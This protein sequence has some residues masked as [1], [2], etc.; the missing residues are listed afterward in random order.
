MGKKIVR[1]FRGKTD[2]E[3]KQ[4]LDLTKK[5]LDEMEIL[6]KGMGIVLQNCP[7]KQKAKEIFELSKN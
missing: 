5:R 6:L 7:F 2:K 4:A 3:L 1:F